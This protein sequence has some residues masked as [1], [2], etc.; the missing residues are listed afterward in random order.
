MK[1]RYLPGETVCNQSEYIRGHGTQQEGEEIKASVLG[2]PKL[3]SKLVSIVPTKSSRY[4]P[5][6]GDV[7]IGRVTEVG[8]KR[9]TIEMNCKAEVTL[10]LTAINLP[11]GVQR[12]KLISDEMNMHRY[13]SIGDLVIAEVQKVN[14]GGSVTLHARSEKY[15]KLEFGVAIELPPMLMPKLRSYF[16]RDKDVEVALGKNGYVFLRSTNKCTE[17]YEKISR[18][19]QKLQYSKENMQRISHDTVSRYLDQS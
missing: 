10:H 12:R 16:F 7:V 14:K 19:Y 2:K 4:S 1:E 3:I 18:L 17:S 8:N 15:K 6:V 5:E 11:G 9:W 13:F